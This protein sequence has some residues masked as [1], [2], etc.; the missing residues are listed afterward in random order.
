MSHQQMK[1]RHKDVLLILIL[2]IGILCLLLNDRLW[3]YE[4]GNL[5]TGKLSDFIGLF[6]LPL[7]L[8]ILFPKVKSKISLVV[9]VLFII[10]KSPLSSPFIELWNSFQIIEFSRVIDKTDYIA[11]L[12]I[13]L[14]HTLIIKYQ[15]IRV[16]AFIIES[17]P[18]VILF[19]ILF[20]S[21]IIF[22]ST[23]VSEPAYP[24]GDILIDEAYQ[25]KNK[26]ELQILNYF[27]K[28]NLRI[29]EDSIVYLRNNRTRF[30]KYYQIEQF[31]A[32]TQ[33]GL[34]TVNNLNF[35][36][37]E[38]IDQSTLSII[39]LTVQS[40]WDLQNWETLKWK[41]KHYKELIEKQI[42]VKIDDIQ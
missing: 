5:L 26:T 7:F 20:L 28:Q 8:S 12:M 19:P 14:V 31:V 22:C 11:L 21:T 13:P 3:K 27:E 23:S 24:K 2:S 41:S 9:G 1:N 17:I 16:R 36:I 29:K 32:I 42:I 6:T 34:D 4:Y 15:L 40:N 25:L 33:N 10:W 38:N 37:Y 35:R 18:K 30:H 39:N